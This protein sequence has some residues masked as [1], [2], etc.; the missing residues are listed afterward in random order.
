MLRQYVLTYSGT[1]TPVSVPTTTG[2]KMSTTTIVQIMEQLFTTE[3]T[4]LDDTTSAFST[5]MAETSSPTGRWTTIT[6]I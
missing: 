2:V 4:A 1:T 5:T 3:T 6:G